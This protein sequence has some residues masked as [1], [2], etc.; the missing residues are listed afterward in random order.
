[1]RLNLS[2]DDVIVKKKRSVKKG[3]LNSASKKLKKLITLEQAT[4]VQ[5]P[6]LEVVIN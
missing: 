2:S 6:K 3:I 5:H 4:L 1:M